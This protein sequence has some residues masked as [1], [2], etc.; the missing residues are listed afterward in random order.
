MRLQAIIHGHDTRAGRAFDFAVLALIL[1]SILTLTIETLPDLSPSTIAFLEWSEIIVT[2]TFT[3]EY[4]LRIATS[5]PRLGY[6]F[7]FYGIIDLIAIAPFYLALGLDLRAVRTLRLLRMF[8]LLKLLRYQAAVRRFA[9]ALYETREEATVF[10]IAALIMLYLAAFGIYQFEHEAQ[11]EHFGSIPDSL[12]WAVATLTTVGYGDV[13]PITIG[14]KLFTFVILMIGLGVIAVPAGL[15]ASALQQVRKGE[16][17]SKP[18][19]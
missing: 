19:R 3:V 2:L 9:Q 13:Y 17:D 12:W 6:V 18:G 15:I 5:R 10:F 7:S 14:G 4:I 1:Y 8:R 16:E 11:P